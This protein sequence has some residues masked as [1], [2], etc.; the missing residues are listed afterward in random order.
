MTP[1]DI[2]DFIQHLAAALVVALACF[3]LLRR[4]R[5]SESASDCTACSG[6]PV[7]PSEPQRR[8]L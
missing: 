6:P 2:P 3:L 8:P 1:I 5:P 4:V 7:G